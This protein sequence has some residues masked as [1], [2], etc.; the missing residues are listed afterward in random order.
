MA[1]QS[2]VLA[3]KRLFLQIIALQAS[4]YAV[5]LLL[6]SF[7]LF[8]AGVPW[9]L[10]YILSWT[11]VTANT[12]LGWLLTVL[13]LLDAMFSVLAIVLIVGR[14]KLA[15]DFALTLHLIN[16]IVVTVYSHSF[17]TSWLWWVLQVLSSLLTVYAGVW[18][19][20]WRE[21]RKTFFEDY[22]LVDLEAQNS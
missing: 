5:G 10:H 21:L 3:P 6:I 13:W 7:A 8:V 15:T 17:P 19:S 14:S 1:K 9:G 11:D 2:P 18:A 4:Y 22:E 20:Q 16:L 12:S